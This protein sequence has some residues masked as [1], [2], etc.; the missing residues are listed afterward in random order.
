MLITKELE[1]VAVSHIM[2]RIEHLSEIE[3]AF[4][5]GFI[6]TELGKRLAMQYATGTMVPYI[7]DKSFSKM[8]IPVLDISVRKKVGSLVQEAYSLRSEANN[9]EIEVQSIFESLVNG[10]S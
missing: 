4:L 8:K 10:V 1:G 5:C 3:N 2:M 7:N 6:S 9:L